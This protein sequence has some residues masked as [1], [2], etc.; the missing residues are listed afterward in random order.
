MKTKKKQKSN[1]RIMITF[2]GVLIL[3][4]LV[5]ACTSIL[6]GQISFSALAESLENLAPGVL[7]VFVVVHIVL[8]LAALLFFISAKKK[9]SG[10]DG[11]SEEVIDS[12]EEKLS[13]SIL[14]ANAATVLNFFGFAAMIQVAENTAYGERHGFLMFPIT[15]VVFILGYVWIIIVSKLVV[16]QEK[17]LNPEKQGNIF[18][19]KFQKEW[20]GSCDENEKQKVYQSGYYG[21]RAGNTTCMIMWILT[22][23][24]QLWTDTGLFPVACVCVI[25]LSMILSSTIGSIR[26]EKHK[27]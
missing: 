18:D 27:G 11:E 25:W 19:V 5:G 26:L 7:P 15:L 9:L 3:S 6:A 4:G 1:L 20:V 24:M 17:K 2:F 16:D 14:L 12:A 22:V 23:L 13:Y 10:W 21:F 8:F